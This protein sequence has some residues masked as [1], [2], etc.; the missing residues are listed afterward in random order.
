MVAAVMF[1]G[2]A[3]EMVAWW[4]VGP[5]GTRVWLVMGLTLPAMGV[6][7]V[8]AGPLSLSPAVALG[9]AAPAGVAAGVALYLATREFMEVV[10]G[11]RVFHQQSAEIYARRGGL[12]LWAVVVFAPG[13]I[14]AGE[15]L[16]W[17]GLFQ[18]HLT[19]ALDGR[20]AGAAA[21][22]LAFAAVNLA[23]RNLAIIAG[24]VVGGA[25]WAALAWWTGGVLA[26]LL[27]HSVWTA[28]MLSFP[29]NR[30]PARETT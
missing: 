21:T 15:E 18:A 23:S 4:A 19:D 8:I 14:V 29:V 25:V 9:L 30:F 12:P 27:C 7:A 17:R 5:H 1:L 16:F 13:L 20:A 11:W 28:L 24:A 26:S 2:V 10:R 22:W 6:A 3:A